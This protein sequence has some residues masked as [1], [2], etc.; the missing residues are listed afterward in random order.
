MHTILYTMHFKG[1]M[2][3]AMTESRSMRTTGGD[4]LSGQHNCQAYRRRFEYQHRRRR[5]CLPGFRVA[6]S[7]LARM[8]RHILKFSTVGHGHLVSSF[9]PGSMAG[10]ASWKVDGRNGQFAA[11]RGFIDSAFMLGNSGVF[12]NV[13]CGWILLP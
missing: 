3:P 12:N 13:H 8:A 6:P 7:R 2:I 10:T 5:P 1:R 4:E 9:E 11:A